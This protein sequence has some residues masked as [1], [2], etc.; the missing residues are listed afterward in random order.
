MSYGSEVG[1]FEL[2]CEQLRTVCER[3]GL[4]TKTAEHIAKDS[5]EKLRWNAIRQNYTTI[6]YN[7]FLM[8]L[9]GYNKNKYI[10]NGLFTSLKADTTTTEAQTSESLLFCCSN[11][12]LTSSKGLCWIVKSVL[13][14]Y[15]K[16]FFVVFL[17]T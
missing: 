6:N 16:S 14:S 12:Q 9:Q 5:F 15:L 3:V 10:E 17:S 7:D 13:S 1:S 8:V 11:H 4:P 2:N